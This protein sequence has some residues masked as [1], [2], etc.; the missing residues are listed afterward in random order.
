MMADT[1]MHCFPP[2][3]PFPHVNMPLGNSSR[4]KTAWQ[5]L[6]TSL[7]P[8]LQGSKHQAG[9]VAAL[10]R[11]SPAPIQVPLASGAAGE[12]RVHLRFKRRR[13]KTPVFAKGKLEIFFLMLKAGKVFFASSVFQ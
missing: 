6:S 3:F 10:N 8:L 12:G 1:A 5:V 9:Q 7:L 11:A 2:P 4:R 13:K